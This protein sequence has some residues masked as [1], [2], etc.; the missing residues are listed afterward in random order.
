MAFVRLALWVVLLAGPPPPPGPLDAAKRHLA[1]GKLDDVLFD[2]EGKTFSGPERP[3]A[4]AVLAE[5]ARLALEAKDPVLALQFVQMALRLD[6]SQPLALET[7]ARSCLSQKQFDPAESYADRLIALDPK[8]SRPRLLRA[9]VALDQ[10]EWAKV[11]E[12]TRAI[13]PEGLSSPDRAQLL[14]GVQ[15]AS[16]E[17]QEREAARSQ[18]KALEAARGRGRAAQARARRQACAEACRGETG[19]RVRRGV[20]WVLPSGRQMASGPGSP[21]RREGHREG[22]G[23]CRRACREAA[24]RGEDRQRHSVD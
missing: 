16:R 14:E 15:T 4:A 11:L 17:L 20:V 10:G 12:L 2:V 24:R 9:Q 18:S 23:S 7:G 22:R 13:D 21:L 3:G 8:A 1:L 5:A 19:H 6:K